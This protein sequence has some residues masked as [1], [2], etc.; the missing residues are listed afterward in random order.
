[1]LVETRGHR[2]GSC[3]IL[4]AKVENDEKRLCECGSVDWKCA[5]GD[6]EENTRR[7]GDERETRREGAGRRCAGGAADK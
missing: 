5:E 2:G 6:R 7:E 1:M 4:V 3:W